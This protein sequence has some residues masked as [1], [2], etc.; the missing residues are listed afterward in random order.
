[1]KTVELLYRVENTSNRLLIYVYE[2]HAWMYDVKFWLVG[3]KWCTELD[4]KNVVGELREYQ[5]EIIKEYTPIVEQHEKENENWLAFQNCR[6]RTC[7][8]KSCMKFCSCSS[9]KEKMS[10]CDKISKEVQL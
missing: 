8:C 3:N 9:C 4:G 5:I 1:M 6:K 2:K 10:H 7:I